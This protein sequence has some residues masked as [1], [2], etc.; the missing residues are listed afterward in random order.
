MIH[1]PGAAQRLANVFQEEGYGVEEFTCGCGCEARSLRVSN[2]EGEP[3]GAIMLHPSAYAA[4]PGADPRAK[5]MASVWAIMEGLR[6]HEL[7]AYID[8]VRSVARVA[9]RFLHEIRDADA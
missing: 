2:Q 6:P 7:E 1:K 3:V 5:A 9:N 8:G 4:L